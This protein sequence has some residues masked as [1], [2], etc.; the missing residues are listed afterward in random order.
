MIPAVIERCAGID[1]GR[2]YID[3][4]LMVGE[5]QA[6]PTVQIK[7]FS[8]LNEDLERM[9]QWLKE[10]QVTHVAMESTGSYWRPIYNILDDGGME[11]VLANSQHIKNL[12]GHKTDRNDARW[13]AHLLRHGMIR[14][15]FIPNRETRELRDLTRR[16][17][18]MVGC[19]ADERNRVQRVLQEANVQLGTVL[20]DV[21]GESGLNMLDRLMK[22]DAT[23]EEIADLAVR[24]ARK[25]I[26]LLKKALEGHRMTDHHRALI[27]HSMEHL[28]F[29]EEEIHEL[30]EEIRKHVKAH[31]SL[32]EATEL[33][34]S[35]N[36]IKETAAA[37]I[38]AETG[39]DI[40]QFSDEGKLSAW[41]GTCPGNN[42]TGGKRKSAP[43]RKGNPWARRVL[44]ECAWSATR[45]KGSE[46][47]RHY[48]HL[49][50]RHKHK[51]ALVAT[52]H[53]LTRQLFETLATGKPYLDKE[54]SELTPTQA[55]RLTRHH[56]RRLKKL[57]HWIAAHRERT[58]KGVSPEA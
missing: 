11:V 31:D 58:N 8:T 42:I 15:S 33:A 7:R 24:Q 32:R 1:V 19:A 45:R 10:N 6:E 5:A 46:A 57:N 27:R 55:Q 37:S 26:P 23:P 34:Q 39:P 18:Q 21:F 4:C 41:I 29:L 38:I 44:V 22:P 40:A 14:P 49:K 35:I 43:A 50:L 52:A 13:I 36:G 2:R 30:D 54:Q 47:Q 28:A 9:R 3:V 51:S 53:L 25:K 17:K 48:E 12:R 20:S 56:S 16:R